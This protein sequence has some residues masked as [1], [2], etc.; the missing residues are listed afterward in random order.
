MPWQNRAMLKLRAMPLGVRVLLGYGL[1]ILAFVGLTLPR[2]VAEAVDLPVSPIGL[3]WML[4][5][6]YAIFT[7]T[8]VL[9][10]KQAGYGLSLGLASLTVPLVPILGYFAGI[11]GAAI[12]LV[13]AIV[14]FATLRQPAARAWFSEP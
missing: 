8:L 2:V 12:P 3:L 5:L 11:P 14:L 9:Q 6:A 13:L 4:L 7:L 1:A 10:R